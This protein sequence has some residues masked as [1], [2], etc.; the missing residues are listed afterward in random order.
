[1]KFYSKL[2]KDII[3]YTA[4]EQPKDKKYI[5]L[6]TN[7]NAYPPTPQIKEVL[8]NFEYQDLLLYPDPDGTELREELAKIKKTSFKNIFLSNGSDEV[9]SMAIAAF[10]DEDDTIAYPQITYSFYDVYADYYRLKKIKIALKD[11]QIDIN[12]YL[13]LDCKGILLAN[14]NAPTGM[15]LKTQEIEELV[16]NNKDKIVIVDQ[17]YI[18]FSQGCSSIELIKEYD[19]LLVVETLSKSHS[20][21]GIRLGYAVGNQNLIDALNRIKNSINSYTVNRL[22]MAVALVAVR[23]GDYYSD[24]TAKIVATRERVCDALTNMGLFVLKS[25]SNFLFI[26]VKNACQVYKELKNRGILVRYFD[27]KGVNDFIRVTIGQD[28]DMDLFLE[29]LKDILA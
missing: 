27:K 19:N 29:N 22:S 28:K 8:R 15:A 2:A 12:D 14:P 4:G 26:K 25:S 5:K 17:A 3:P 16:K 11:Y 24:I 9:L 18:A 13:G 7:E 1:M 10:F 20:L 23:D 6:N 21:A